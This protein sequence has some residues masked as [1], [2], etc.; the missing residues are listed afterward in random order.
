MVMTVIEPRVEPIKRDQQLRAILIDFVRLIVPTIFLVATYTISFY[1][2]ENPVWF[3]LETENVA[4]DPAWWMS[5]GHLT[6][7]LAFFQV[8][9]TNRAHGPGMAI[10]RV[11]FAWLVILFFLGIA[12][13]L[14][15]FTELRAELMP[16]KVMSAF[17]IGLFFGHL[18]AI[19]AFDWQR[20]V[21]W[22]KAPLIA[23]LIGPLVFVL[24]FYPFGYAGADVP[25]GSWLWMHFVALASVGIV[26]MIPYAMLRRRIKPASGLGGA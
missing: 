2:L 20:G 6:L 10:S 23:A 21:P 8:A 19:L 1:L 7:G 17:L 3:S 14:Y 26:M 24:I 18:A 9:L 11:V 16:T 25:W 4:A 15:G 12:G 13:S 22:W 5:L